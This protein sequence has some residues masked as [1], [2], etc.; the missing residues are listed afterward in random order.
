MYKYGTFSQQFLCPSD[1]ILLRLHGV[2]VV[3]CTVTEN[4]GLYAHIPFEGILSVFYFLCS[5]N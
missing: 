4:G 5:I 3:N 1:K 2:D